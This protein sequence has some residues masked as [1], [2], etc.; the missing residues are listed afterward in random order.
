M[1]LFDEDYFE[2]G[3]EK[4]VSLYTNFRWMPERSI[5]E[6]HWIINHLKMNRYSSII[7]YGCAKGFHVRALRLLGYEAY[8]YDISDY[9]L[10]CANNKVAKYLYNKIKG[11]YD[12]GLC[13]DT[14]EHCT[15][16]HQLEESLQILA[17]LAFK[18]LIIIPNAKDGKY[19]IPDIAKDVTHNIKLNKEDWDLILGDNGLEIE[20]FS[21]RLFGLKDNWASYKKGN[22]FYIVKART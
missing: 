17:H 14:L 19:V 4:G 16:L 21:Y 15:D 8:G 5:P 10:S 12:Y 18:W 13:K 20:E 11:R 7:D 2:H 22:L 1:S 3:N 9:A 6:A